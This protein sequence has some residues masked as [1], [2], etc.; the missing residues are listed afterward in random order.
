VTH[1]PNGREVSLNSRMNFGKCADF[2]YFASGSG[3]FELGCTPRVQSRS[4]QNVPFCAA[5]SGLSISIISFATKTGSRTL[6][7]G[8]SFG[9]P[10]RVMSDIWA[11]ELSHDSCVSNYT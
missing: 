11:H 8:S 1:L 10:L 2:V 7:L 4:P 6:G 3:G 9:R 5:G